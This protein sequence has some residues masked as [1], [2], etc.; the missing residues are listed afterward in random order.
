MANRTSIDII[1]IDPTWLGQFVEKDFLVDLTNRTQSWP[2][3][4][5]MY[6]AF[7]DAG[8][9]NNKVYGIY[10]IGDIRAL[11]GTGR[12]YWIMQALNLVL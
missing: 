7:L 8:V 11:C 12:I 10:I 6:Q 5:D 9:Y 2:G 4:E 1:D 3:L